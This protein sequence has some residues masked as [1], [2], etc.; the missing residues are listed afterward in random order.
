MA[1][2]RWPLL[3]LIV[4]LP[5]ILLAA[6]YRL[7]FVGSNDFAHPQ[8]VPAGDFEIAWFNTTT[9]GTA[10]E[11]FVT[12]V[13]RA[14]N[15]MPG[16]RVELAG[17]FPDQTTDVPEIILTD[18]GQTTRLRIRWYKLSSQHS[19]AD[20]ISRLSSRRPAP[21]AIIGGG[22]S[23]R[24]RDLAL[25]LAAQTQWQGQRPLFFITTAT[26]QSI[27]H[28]GANRSLVGLYPNRT[29]RFCFS[30]EQMA[31]ALLDFIWSNSELRPQPLGHSAGQ[32]LGSGL[33]A[34]A[35]QMLH[36]PTL[37]RVEWEDDPYSSDFLDE[38]SRALPAV[39]AK[40]QITADP[41]E[42]RWKVPF[43]VGRFATA[44]P[45]EA[46][47]AAAIMREFQH[48]PPERALLV[49]PTVPAPARRLLRRLSEAEPDVGRR[50]IAVNGDGMG[51]NAVLRD[52]EYVWPIAALPVP[53]LLFTHAHPADWDSTLQP[54]SSTDDV[55]HTAELI[56][57]LVTAFFEPTPARDADMLAARLHGLEPAFFDRAGN[58]LGGVGEYVFLLK[59]EEEIAEVWQ[60]GSNRAWT[61][62][63]IVSLAALREPRP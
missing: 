18:A 40:Y 50:F 62:L 17:A 63:R 56:R 15:L 21:L 7:P 9:G 13:Q 36:R 5:L 28:D 2:L 45:L 39:L 27:F 57:I 6:G 12:G 41:L 38:T 53:L 51:V 3:I 26:A 54:P 48:L 29:F 47:I 30:N 59:P 35:R 33:A 11:R 31:E 23:D 42:Y 22:S 25:A 49:I 37:F 52:G 46:A 10:W 20:W 4:C 55:L 58:R 43:S 8:P 14:R 1:R 44:H 60:R 24:A 32:A 19:E 61:L 34:A 16:L